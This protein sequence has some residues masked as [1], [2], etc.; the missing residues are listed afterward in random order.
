MNFHPFTIYSQHFCFMQERTETKVASMRHSNLCTLLSTLLHKGTYSFICKLY[1]TKMHEWLPHVAYAFPRPLVTLQA[2]LLH[3]PFLLCLCCL[4]TSG[5]LVVLEIP[6]CVISKM[7]KF[8]LY[9]YMF[10]NMGLF[11]MGQSQE[12]LFRPRWW[13]AVIHLSKRWLQHPVYG[14]FI[15]TFY[16]PLLAFRFCISS[17]AANHLCSLCITSSAC[18]RA[19][20]IL[21][22]ILGMNSSRTAT[23]PFLTN[24]YASFC[25]LTQAGNFPLSAWSHTCGKAIHPSQ[26]IAIAI[27]GCSLWVGILHHLAQCCFLSVLACPHQ[28]VAKQGLSC[29]NSVDVV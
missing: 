21:V 5:F 17:Q 10:F 14:F 6:Q 16:L 19:I 20:H 23:N 18:L 28:S 15:A 29:V 26:W 12:I 2:P 27:D 24:T 9:A 3:C 8:R 11:S 4:E 13:F 1:F 22:R 7:P 25:D